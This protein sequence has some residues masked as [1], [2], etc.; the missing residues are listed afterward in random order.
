MI[1]KH[2]PVQLP[3]FISASGVYIILKYMSSPLF[4]ILRKMGNSSK[5]LRKVDAIINKTFL[6]LTENPDEKVRIDVIPKLV[7]GNPLP[8]LKIMLSDGSFELL[9]TYTKTPLLLIFV[10][11]SWCSYSRLHLSDIES[12]KDSFNKKGIHIL[13]V[14]S[15]MDQKWWYANGITIP[16]IVDSKGDIFKTFGVL[17]KSWIDYAWGRVLPH[18]SI[19]LFNSSGILVVSDV[20]KVNS[21]IPGQRFLGSKK[22]LKLCDKYL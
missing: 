12:K 4:F 15:Y 11:G 2:H 9:D 7:I 20:R 8:K 6:P 16:M 19:F 21:I 3:F 18:E 13:A 22:W 1:S 14:T 17:L 10:R 5:L